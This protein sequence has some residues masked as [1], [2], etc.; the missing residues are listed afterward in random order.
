MYLEP[1]HISFGRLVNAGFFQWLI[2][3]RYQ[4][5]GTKGQNID[6]ALEEADQKNRY[7]FREV[8]KL[9]AGA[10]NEEDYIANLRRELTA[11]L[12]LPTWTRRLGEHSAELHT[13]ISYLLSGPGESKEGRGA[14]NSLW[15][16]LFCW[17]FTHRLADALG[18]TDWSDMEAEIQSWAWAD[19]WLLKKIS[20]TA[21]KEMGMEHH[22]ASRI[23]DAMHL[24][25]CL[26]EWQSFETHQQALQNWFT[27]D[28]LLRFLGVNRHQDILW[29]KREAFLEFLWWLF[30][31]WMIKRLPQWSESS[32]IQNADAVEKREKEIITAYRWI[33]K[34][35]E[36]EEKSGYQVEKLLTG[37]FN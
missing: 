4:E 7:V 23:L 1:L 12:S 30:A 32:E 31:I 17:V 24:V 37:E 21:L 9:T 16:A 15:G 2:A 36:L 5:D 27:N 25:C 6:Q 10:G 8:I 34:L 11:V 19:E 3:N 13:A 20:R 33:E 26:E 35:R 22:K 28:E 14:N 29:F 18:R